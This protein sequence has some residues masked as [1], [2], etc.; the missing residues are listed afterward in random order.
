MNYCS[1]LD[2]VN[3]GYSERTCSSTSG[4]MFEGYYGIQ[5]LYH[6]KMFAHT[7]SLAPEYADAP[8]VF[9]TFPETPFHYGS[10]EGTVRSQAHVCFRGRRVGDYRSSGLLDLRPAGLFRR[11]RN[12]EVFFRT[13]QNLFQLLKVPGEVPHARA[14]LLLDELLLQIH[15]Q[16]ALPDRLSSHYVNDLLALRDRIAMNPLADWD[17]QKEA[18][19]MELSY[20][21][22]RRIFK[23]VT[24][25]PPGAFLLECRLRQAEKMLMNSHARIAETAQECGF[26]DA[27]HFSRIFKKHCGHSPA[28]FRKRYGLL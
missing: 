4:R 13:M 23:Q 16:P 1:D 17:F 10:P 18:R 20:V 2:F 14:V 25:W 28:E 7:G 27:Y 5:F 11:L 26:A 9:I 21:H 6:G 19:K 22:F 15:E 12:P 3:Y 8:A 24:N